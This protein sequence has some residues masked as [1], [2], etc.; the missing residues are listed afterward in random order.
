MILK[1]ILM[2]I[3]TSQTYP[4]KHQIIFYSRESQSFEIT[5]TL[6]QKS[7]LPFLRSVD[8]INQKIIYIFLIYRTPSPG[9]QMIL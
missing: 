3:S 8:T 4:R 1:Q 5:K 7:K 6:G 9:P 2:G